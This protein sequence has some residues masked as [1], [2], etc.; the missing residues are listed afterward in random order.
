MDGVAGGGFEGGEAGG[1]GDVE[2]GLGGEG[3]QF[4]VGFEE[5]RC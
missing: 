3:E 1:E 5:V 2:E 4:V